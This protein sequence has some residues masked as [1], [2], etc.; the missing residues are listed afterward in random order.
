MSKPEGTLYE[1][2]LF[3]C[4]FASYAKVKEVCWKPKDQCYLSVRTE[5]S[6][7]NALTKPISAAQIIGLLAFVFGE[8]EGIIGLL[9]AF[10]RFKI[11]ESLRT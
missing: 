5:I 6:R 9:R 3:S 11:N 4:M 7:P 2:N 8:I 10:C 1:L